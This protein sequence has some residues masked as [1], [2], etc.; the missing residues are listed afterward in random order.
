MFPQ[1]G[2]NNYL[3]RGDS[4]MLAIIRD[5]TWNVISMQRMTP[6]STDEIIPTS[7]VVALKI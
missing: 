5:D 6:N 2:Q 7:L 1:E 3:E 4:L